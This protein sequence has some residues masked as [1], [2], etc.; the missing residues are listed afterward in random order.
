[1]KTTLADR[2]AAKVNKKS[3]NECWPWIGSSNCKGYG[4]FWVTNRKRSATQVSWEIA[5]L[6]PFPLGKIACH[7]CDNPPCVNPN[8]IFPGTYKDN[9]QDAISKGRFKFVPDGHRGLKKKAQTHCKHG[10]EFTV[11]NTI[12]VKIGGKLSG[13][14]C[15]ACYRII[16]RKRD[17]NGRRRIQPINTRLSGT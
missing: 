4:N 12:L 10:H 5:N 6:V 1:M 13:R 8:H 2:F 7:Y 15:R 16:D 14:K 11:E 3:P 9:T 17:A